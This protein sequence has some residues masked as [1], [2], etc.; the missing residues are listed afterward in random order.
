MPETP[1]SG[2]YRIVVGPFIYIGSATNFPSRRYHHLWLLKKGRHY[3]PML[4]KAFNEE[5]DFA[6]QLHE[7]II[8]ADTTVLRKAEQGYITELRKSNPNF[9]CNIHNPFPWDPSDEEI[10]EMVGEVRKTITR[11]ERTRQRIAASKQGAKH[12]RARAVIVTA[13]N[14][15][16]T[17]YPT[18]TAAAA[19]FKVSQQAMDQWMRGVVAFPGKDPRVGKEWIWNYKAEFKAH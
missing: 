18:V 1:L 7:K 5:Q 2:I 15:E 6:F 19:F 11:S 14:G 9:L 3:N 13:P 4:Q 16:E 10:R 12:P 17:E 8:T